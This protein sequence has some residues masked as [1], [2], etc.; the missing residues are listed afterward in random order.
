MSFQ[1][2]HIEHA[3]SGESPGPAPFGETD[4]TLAA[5]WQAA[6]SAGQMAPLPSDFVVFGP[7]EELVDEP[8]RI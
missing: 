6:S 5:N 1:W 3:T 7:P 2:R 4:W 8:I